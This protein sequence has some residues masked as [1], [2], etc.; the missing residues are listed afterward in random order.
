M[1]PSP[2]IVRR[3]QHITPVEFHVAQYIGDMIRSNFERMLE[4]KKP[5]ATADPVLFFDKKYVD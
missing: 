5:S 1:S 2:P 4:S 3:R